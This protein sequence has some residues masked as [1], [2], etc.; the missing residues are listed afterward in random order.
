MPKLTL[1]HR[2]ALR[3][4]ARLNFLSLS[5]VV[6]PKIGVRLFDRAMGRLSKCTLA[7]R[8]ATPGLHGG[9]LAQAYEAPSL[10]ESRREIR[11]WVT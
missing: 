9:F 8:L 10:S 4:S 1:A 11:E 2:R 3:F 5:A 7:G 6:L